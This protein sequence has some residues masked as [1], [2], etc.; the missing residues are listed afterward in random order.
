[1]PMQLPTM[2]Q[3]RSL[4]CL[5]PAAIVRLLTVRLDETDME[6]RPGH[7]ERWRAD[8]GARPETEQRHQFSGLPCDCGQVQRKGW[9]NTA[10]WVN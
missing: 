7:P 4:W 2:A 10:A 6:A 8:A 1:M 3:E 9:Q 5:G